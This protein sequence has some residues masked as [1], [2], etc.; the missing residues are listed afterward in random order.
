MTTFRTQAGAL[1]AVAAMAGAVAKRQ[2]TIPILAHLHLAAADGCIEVKGSNLEIDVA[3]TVAG[4][5][6][7]PA[8]TVSA[9]RL[10]G[11]LAGLLP[12]ATVALSPEATGQLRIEAGT[13]TARL[14]TLPAEDFPTLQQRTGEAAS[15]T[16]PAGVLLRL[17][18]RPAHAISTGETRYNLNGIYLHREGDRLRAVATDGHRMFVADEAYPAEAKEIPPAI[19]PRLAAV[20][21][22]AALRRLPTDT[23]VTWQQAALWAAL[24][25]RS[26]RLDFKLIDGTFPNYRA[27]IPDDDGAPIVVRD[28]R[29]L[30][31]SVA[32]VASISD[33]RSKPVRLSNGSGTSL[34]I[35]AAAPGQGECSVA[36]EPEVAA[37]ASD[38]EH[39]TVGI[40]ARYLRDVCRAFPSGFTMR[41]REGSA[42]IHITGAEGLALLM[43]MRI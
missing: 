27:V 10:T 38:A 25:G 3:A 43:P 19:V 34:T 22:R 24:I 32:T 33:E 12:E 1:R 31:Q 7:L 16:L 35:G 36:I 13:L 5:G 26:W 17:L 9:A 11:I 28:A 20:E 23:A 6:D 41:V 4:E 42:P 21:A 40:Q 18:E 15:L 8:T 37:W 39:P 30:G 2:G 14:Y 29:R